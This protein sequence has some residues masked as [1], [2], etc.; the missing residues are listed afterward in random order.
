MAES[1][2]GLNGGKTEN[3]PGA[4]ALVGRLLRR[5]KGRQPPRSEG[6]RTHRLQ[7]RGSERSDGGKAVEGERPEPRRSLLSLPLRSAVEA[8]VAD[9]GRTGLAL[10]DATARRR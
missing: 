6:K 7:Q 9:G 4:A 5:G 10:A 2:A 8:G 3:T 1:R